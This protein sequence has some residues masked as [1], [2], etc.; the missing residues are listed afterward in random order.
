MPTA[1]D[2]IYYEI[3]ITYKIFIHFGNN[4]C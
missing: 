2:Y 1:I 4:L 3:T